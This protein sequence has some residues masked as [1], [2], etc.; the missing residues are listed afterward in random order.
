MSSSPSTIISCTLCKRSFPTT[1]TTTT[2]PNN[3]IPSN[4]NSS[5]EQLICTNCFQTSL[6]STIPGRKEFLL[7]LEQTHIDD[8]QIQDLQR[9]IELLQENLQLRKKYLQDCKTFLERDLK[10]LKTVVVPTLESLTKVG[11]ELEQQLSEERKRRITQLVNFFPVDQVDGTIAEI[12]LFSNTTTISHIPRPI[13]HSS[14]NESI[15]GLTLVSRLVL[16]VSH[17]LNIPLPYPV[18]F[19]LSVAYISTPSSGV[20]INNTILYHLPLDPTRVVEFKEA[21][22]LLEFNIK[23]LCRSQGIP[24]SAL[25]DNL[26][27]NLWQ[28]LSSPSL[29]KSIRRSLLDARS[30]EGSRKSTNV[31]TTTTTTTTT[32]SSHLLDGST[33]NNSND[34]FDPNDFVM[35]KMGKTILGGF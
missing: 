28:L 15:F 32:Q 11:N 7:Q 14:T 34:Y 19:K 9:K 33:R 26:V 22:K 24:Q 29:G 17:Y 13:N 3:T 35:V 23:I 16:I 1:T 20:I 25:Q 6:S 31:I 12:H 10:T 30:R 5:S 18:S 4:T 21:I 27:D 8:K 2:T